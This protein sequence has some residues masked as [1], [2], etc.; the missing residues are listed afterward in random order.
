MAFQPDDSIKYSEDTYWTLRFAGLDFKN[1]STWS[2]LLFQIM[3][4]T[5]FILSLNILYSCTLLLSIKKPELVVSQ[6]A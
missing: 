3:E 5:L 4:V 1:H 2:L 6:T